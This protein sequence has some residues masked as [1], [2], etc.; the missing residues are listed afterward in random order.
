MDG[1]CTRGTRSG[2]GWLSELCGLG[3][4]GSAR[5]SSCGCEETGEANPSRKGGRKT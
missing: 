2:L 1:M 4:A 5:Y 3:R